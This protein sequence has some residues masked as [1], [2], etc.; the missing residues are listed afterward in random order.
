MRLFVLSDLHLEKCSSRRL[1]EL[2]AKFDLLICAGDLWEGEPAL[3]V[4]AAAALADGRPTI[5]VPG[6][7]DRYRRGQG[8]PRTAADLLLAMESEAERI[9]EEAGHPRVTVLHSGEAISLDG[10]TFLGATLWTDWS[11]ASRW[12][13]G[14]PIAPGL[15]STPETA[16]EAA[17]RHVVDAE[18]GSREFLGDMAPENGVPWSPSAAM[19]AHRRDRSLLRAA[20][21]KPR[22]GPIV[23]VTHHTPLPGPIDAYRGREG[24]PW[25]IPAFYCSTFLEDLPD[26]LRPELWVSGHFHATH[27]VACGR[28]RCVAN[29]FAAA[30]FDPSFVV[31]I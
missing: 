26:H 4:R 7:H 15:S 2:A 18:T 27:D 13:D 22:S 1:P 29:P 9:N 31:E 25:W 19:A 20:L 17:I 14:D 6:N 8:D 21:E 28:T 11:L 24:V 16:L 30:A 3:G 12:I 5:I 10:T 23:V